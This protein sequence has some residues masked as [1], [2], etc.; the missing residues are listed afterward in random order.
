MPRSPPRSPPPAT[1]LGDAAGVGQQRHLAGV[2]DRHGDVGLLL[3]VVAGDPA[4]ADLGPVGHEPA[5]QVDVLVV[6]VV[7][8]LL[9]QD[10]DLLLGASRVVLVLGALGLGCHQ[11]G[12]SPS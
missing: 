7:D 10:A 4:G 11:N 9:G 8:R 12:S 1:L 5:E 2:L 3:G 6:D